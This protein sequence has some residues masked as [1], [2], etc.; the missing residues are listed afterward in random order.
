MN[1]KLNLVF[2]MALGFSAWET[3]AQ[4]PIGATAPDFAFRDVTG[5]PHTLYSYLNSGKAVVI[6][7][8]A[9]W[10]PPCWKY[11]E[12]GTLES[13][14]EKNGPPGANK[15]MTLGIEGDGYTNT[16]CLSGKT[17]CNYLTEGN[18]LEGTLY[19]VIDIP[20]PLAR[21]FID[22]AYKVPGYP[23]IYLICP[24][25]K[26]AVIGIGGT[27]LATLEAKLAACGAPTA[28]MEA[29]IGSQVSVYPGITTGSVH[30]DV[31]GE[32]PAVNSVDVY[33]ASGGV[34]FTK[35]AG[36]SGSKAF[37][38]DLTA[39]RNGVYFIQVKTAAGGITR[40]IIL[41]R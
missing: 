10:C 39:Q 7:V 36:A 18:W 33:D 12:G 28:T 8:F 17:G 4:L 6:D 38:F 25:K 14:Y 9:T 32:G 26:I 20:T 15:A 19:P 22:V 3:K 37:K 30:V 1:K 34:I 5:V 29:G 27:P 13:F 23:T 21:H 40:K 16:A 35:N 31:G 24:D 11:H 41:E 2:A